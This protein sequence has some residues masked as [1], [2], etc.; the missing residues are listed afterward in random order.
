[1]GDITTDF[2]KA[3]KKIHADVRAILAALHLIGNDVKAINDQHGADNYQGES[4]EKRQGATMVRSTK[5]QI[6]TYDA[7]QYALDRLRFRMEKKAFRVG[8]WTV[9]ILGVYTALTGYQSCL[10]RQGIKNNAEQFIAENRP[11]LAFEAVGFPDPKGVVTIQ[12]KNTGKTP[13]THATDVDARTR[14]VD[15]EKDIAAFWD[16][17]KDEVFPVRKNPTEVISPNTAAQTQSTPDG[18]YTPQGTDSQQILVVYGR[19][20]YSGAYAKGEHYWTEFCF[21]LH[22]KIKTAYPWSPCIYHNEMH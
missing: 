2:I 16:K 20:D 7:K 6:N 17:W 3:T 13:A 9:A 22:T 12:L 10:T 4:G 15:G 5:E 8:I 18:D 21:E 19:V 1:M 11:W 14:V